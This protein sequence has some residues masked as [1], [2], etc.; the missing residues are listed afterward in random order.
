MNKYEFL[1]TLEQRNSI[2][3]L[4][5]EHIEI[6]SSNHIQMV[7][8]N[9]TLISHLEDNIIVNYIND[10]PIHLPSEDIDKVPLLVLPMSEKLLNAE[11]NNL[12]SQFCNPKFDYNNWRENNGYKK[13]NFNMIKSTNNIK[14]LNT[15]NKSN[16]DIFGYIDDIIKVFK[17]KKIL[18]VAITNSIENLYSD[19]FF[20]N[21]VNSHCV[22]L[23]L[24]KRSIIL[25]GKYDNDFLSLIYLIH[26]VGHYI[27]N[28]TKYYH[29]KIVSLE[30]DEYWAHQIESILI[31][32][33]FSKEHFHLYKDILVNMSNENLLFTEFQQLIYNYPEYY[34]SI[35]LK[36]K[37]FSSLLKKYDKNLSSTWK[38]EEQF[39]SSPFNSGLYVYPQINAIKTLG[40]FKLEDLSILLKIDNK[41]F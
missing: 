5:N 30:S 40:H 12:I 7:E 3:F 20:T 25:H 11:Y 23:P 37:L 33:I 27:F 18:P 19:I 9:E 14:N 31:Y 24:S 38:V 29:N 35:R 8:E 1:T 4:S 34:N 32:H 10:Y 16:R 39:F 17:N 41:K 22:E 2:E 36:D 28:L 6:G 13:I 21:D 15:D 26:E